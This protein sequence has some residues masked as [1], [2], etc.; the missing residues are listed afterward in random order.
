LVLRSLLI[1]A[2]ASILASPA[3]AQSPNALTA[4]AAPIY[5]ELAALKGMTAP[6]A[7]PPVLL[8]SR[9]ETRRFIEQELDRRYTADRVEAERKGMVAW[10][11][12]P[13]AY[14]LR[15]LFVE[16]MQE[17]LAAYYDPRAKVMVLAD[18][19]PPDQQQVAL[20]HE[21]VHAL[22]DREVSLETFL[23]PRP[24]AGD[25]VLARQA[26]IEGEAVG[27]SFE[28]VLKSQ[29][30]ELTSLPDLGP[31]KALA[32]SGAAGATI[33]AAPKFLRDLLT[34]PYIEGL[35]FV[36]ELRKREP[37]SAISALY[38][39]PPRSTSQI[40]NPQKRL[41]TREDPVSITLPDLGAI[42]PGVKEVMTDEL[43]EFGLGAMLGLQL[44]EPAGLAAAAGWRGDQYRVWE[45]ASGRLS[46]IY[47]VA[48]ESEARARSLAAAY[49]T[50]LEKRRTELVGKRVSDATGPRSTWRDGER[51]S[52]VEVRG[53]ELLAIEQMPSA[54]ADAAREAI[55]R[56][57]GRSSQ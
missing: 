9:A 28:L 6:G 47:L 45:D 14:D 40:L 3:V 19:L 13:P 44:G 33:A 51:I 23:A 41:G 46:L 50:A 8:K 29:G 36:F 55:W 35:T 56:S 49:T 53:P 18:W 5:Q 15:R 38:R 30:A 48:M 21:L 26:L 54:R 24:S 42:A 32:A 57:R 39:D 27:L 22:Q 20:V 2:V 11:L 4:A 10:G 12:I 34:F 16:M 7:P 37:W 17:Q 1:A 43:G 31:L 25:Q 52:L